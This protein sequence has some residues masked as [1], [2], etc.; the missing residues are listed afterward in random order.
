VT[1][2]Q[3]TGSS[4]LGALEGAVLE[5]LWT[6][7]ELATPA[8]FDL[9]GKPRGLAYTTI[10]TVLQRLHRKGLLNREE[11]GK[12]HLYSPAI[13]RAD[14]AERRGQSLA[15][16]LVDL[17]SVGVSAFLAEASRLDPAVIELMRKELGRRE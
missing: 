14:F 5:A 2:G 11:R 9:V 10:L 17:G 4:S 15:G 12:S 7:G 8:V 16:V 3:P 1:P 13:T 6:S